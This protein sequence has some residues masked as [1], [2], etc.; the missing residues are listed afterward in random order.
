MRLFVYELGHWLTKMMETFTAPL[1]GG[2]D[3]IAR[4]PAHPIAFFALRLGLV[5]NTRLPFLP[6]RCHAEGW[7]GT[8]KS[9]VFTCP[10]LR[11]PL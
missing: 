4:L 8:L 7:P 2:L 3:P 10:T 6:V 11:A 5:L 1:N 9:M